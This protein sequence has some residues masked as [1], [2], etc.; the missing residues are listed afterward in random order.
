MSANEIR[1]AIREILAEELLKFRAGEGDAAGHPS[2]SRKESVLLR[3][4][5]DLAAFV[6]KVVE[7]AQDPECAEALRTGRM[8]FRL[9]RVQES[10][11]PRR[12]EEDGAGQAVRIDGKL[13]TESQIA[14]VPEG[15][16]V[17]I[18]ADARMTPL[19]Q[20]EM[21]RRRLKPVRREE[22]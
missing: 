11:S 9:D 16:A 7:L 19:A 2:A 12:A 13:I 8:A 3:D 5:A 14:A 4:D 10:P 21:R 6:R 18:G 20:D 1:M 17:E 22:G 15:S